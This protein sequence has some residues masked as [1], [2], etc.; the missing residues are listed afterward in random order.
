[1]FFVIFVDLLTRD[2]EVPDVF[3]DFRR[4]VDQGHGGS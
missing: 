1:M 4:P 3:R 2:T